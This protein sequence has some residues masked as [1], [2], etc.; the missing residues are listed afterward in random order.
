MTEINRF[1][2]K[3]ILLSISLSLLVDTLSVHYKLNLII[4]L[5]KY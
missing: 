4:N 2:N 5:D 3:I 1:M